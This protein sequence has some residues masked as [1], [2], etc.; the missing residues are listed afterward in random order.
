M[1]VDLK[2]IDLPVCQIQD[3]YVA[4]PIRQDQVTS[5][6]LSDGLRYALRPASLAEYA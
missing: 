4:R 3:V 2:M 6:R 1:S 5:L